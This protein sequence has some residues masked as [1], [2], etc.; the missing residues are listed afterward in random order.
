M[1]HKK[2][3]VL[4]LAM[5]AVLFGCQ[6][7]HVSSD[8]R[9]DESLRYVLDQSK[10]P[11]YSIFQSS[12][13]DTSKDACAAFGDYVNG[14]WLAANDVPPGHSSWDVFTILD[15]RSMA[16]RHQLAAQ[17]AQAEDPN[18][19]EKIVGDLWITGMDE[20]KINAQGIEP[21]KADLA[22]IEGLRDK[23][24]IV[25][26]LHASAAKGRN[27]LFG[28]GAGA[29]F[30]NSAV[31]M[32]YAIQGGLGL[33]D[34]AY[35]I[36]TAH[37]DE[38]K[39]YQAHVAKVLEL[40]GIAAMDA[41]KQAEE[42]VRFE[43]RLAK[44]S[45]TASELSR[46]VRL[47]YNPITLAEADRLAPNFSWTEFFESQGV[48]T[49]E[50]FSLAMPAFH[51]EVSRALGDT[52]PS[53]WRAYLRFHAVDDA[54][55]YL[56]DAFAQENYDF[57]ERFLNGQ[58]EQRPRWKHV[59]GTIDGSV[60]EAFGQLYVKAAFSPEAKAKMEKLVM[61]LAAALKER[62]LRLPWMDEETKA[63]AIAKW[64][65]FTAKVGYPEKW[66]DWSGL[67]TQRDSYLDNVRRAREF[68]YKFD[69][70]KIG[71]PVD[72]AEWSMTPQTVNAYYSPLQ[73]EIVFPAAILQPPF[74]DPEADDALNYGGIGALIGHEMTHGYDDQGSRFGPT[75]NIEDWWS[76]GDKLNY[77]ALAGKLVE[78]FDEYRVDGQAV[79]G[80]LTLGENIADLGGLATAYDALQRA[81]AGKDDPG[82]DTF[83]RE[84][85][86]FFSWATIWRAKYA[87]ENAK[88]RLAAGSHAPAQFR[89]VGA[90]SN[91]PAFAAAFQC[92][93]GSP[94]ARSEDERVVI[95]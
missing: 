7:K 79:N 17:A 44:A 55:P 61:N 43:I 54:S 22:A 20:A 90:P 51:E 23:A 47:Y 38:L 77:E 10:L 40:S 85:R 30:K 18:H 72:E 71:R 4:G 93:A 37:A 74:F 88:V 68:N 41:V 25:D 63:K 32:A 2:Y 12:D 27:V 64:E 33:P 83:T 11:A 49:P 46:D 84:Q 67:Q 91:L 53:V 52:D 31:N 57:Y 28:F 65:I 50:K 3:S 1:N 89:V 58:R 6:N 39:A 16:V 95:W 29:D 56:A 34:S 81:S 42:V 73:N 48:A 9:A 5:S 75:G 24:A 80:R 60:G 26:Y 21:L 62:I 13:L 66:R 94:M 14:K 19:I 86:F 59:L 45:R 15:E 8:G 36:D 87:A 92:E 69:L 70:S 76:P 35:Y 78:Q 82:I